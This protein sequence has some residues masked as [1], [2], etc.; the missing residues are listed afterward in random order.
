MIERPIA[1]V[2]SAAHALTDDLLLTEVNPSDVEGALDKHCPDWPPRDREVA[3]RLAVE[4]ADV[5]GTALCM[6]L[7]SPVSH[8]E[9]EMEHHCFVAY[10]LSEYL[11]LPV[12]VPW[13][14]EDRE[15]SILHRYT[16]PLCPEERWP[17]TSIVA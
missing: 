10:E 1:D 7:D 16:N 14:D 3:I 11:D 15:Q 4:F 12:L 6:A 9:A 2:I 13:T 8:T 17:A 5:K